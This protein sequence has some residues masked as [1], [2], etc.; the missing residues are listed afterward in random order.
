MHE[1]IAMLVKHSWMQHPCKTMVGLAAE[2]KL[3]AAAYTLRVADYDD[4][5]V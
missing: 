2:L 1:A 4:S 3:R 5:T